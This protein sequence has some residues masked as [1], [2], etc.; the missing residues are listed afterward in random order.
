MHANDMK[1]GTQVTASTIVHLGLLETCAI[2]SIPLNVVIII[3]TIL[4]VV[5][6]IIFVVVVVVLV[7]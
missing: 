4:L 2:N 5:V 1:G 6:I 7:A 3:V